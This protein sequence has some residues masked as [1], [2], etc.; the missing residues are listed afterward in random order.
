LARFHEIQARLRPHA[1]ALAPGLLVVGLMLVWAVHDGGYD[2]DTWYWGALLSLALLALV[3]IWPGRESRYTRLSRAAIACLALYVAWSYLSITWAQSPGDALQGSN[4]A[5]LY[6]IVFALL[7]RLPWTPQAAVFALLVFAV[8]VGAIAI[9][10][11]VRLGSADHVGV[12]FVYGRLAAPT[13]YENATAG[14]F[15]IQA[16][17]SIALATRRELPGPLRGLLLALA[18]AGLQLAVVDQSRGWLFT[19][20]LVAIVVIVVVADRLRFTAAAVIPVVATLIPVKRL[21][22][23]YDAYTSPGVSLNHASARAGQASLLLCA[24]VFVFATLLAWGDQ[25]VRPPTLSRAA[26]RLIGA[27]VA[28]VAVAGGCGGALVVTRGHPFSFIAREWHGF[29]HQVTLSSSSHFTDVGSGRYDVWRVALDAVIAHP[30]GGLGQDN[31]ADYFVT[32][33]HITE[34]LMWTHSLELRLLAHTGFV[35]FALFTAF[36]VLAL[37]AAARGRRRG[38]PLARAVAGAALLPLVVWLIHGSIDWFWEMPALSGPAL[39]FLG[40]AV[41]LGGAPAHGPTEFST[42]EVS[43]AGI[44]RSLP[45]IA[46]PAGIA[47]GGAA[48]VAAAV[49]LAFPYLSVREV[50][51][52]SDA[53]AGNPTAALRELAT[54]AR[55]NPLSADPGRLAGTI[56]LQTGRLSIARGRFTQSIAREPGG[57]FAWLG[58]GLAE[59]E[60]GHRGAARHDFRVAEAINSVQPAVRQALARVRSTHPL[61]SAE[62]FRLLVVIQ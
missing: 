19:L 1:A 41:A 45:A 29:T 35:G 17:V 23:V 16:L 46:R 36:M 3:M 59:S 57:W 33:R 20:P 10:L 31:F 7:A 24:G 15:T 39:G 60:M 9:V 61:T 4:R 25:L 34:E 30:I 6:L 18:T 32:R 8:G 42:D 28:A 12:L 43:A 37:L 21:L 58:A 27:L 54:A 40:L 22:H 56:A 14:L 44:R 13:G 47:A 11:L 50:S 26:R 55:L 2:A 52:A 5:L 48:L 49:V 38:P 51:I 53:R 62:A